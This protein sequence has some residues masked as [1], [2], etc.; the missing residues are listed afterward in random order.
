MTWEAAITGA[1]VGLVGKIVWDWLAH[2]GKTNGTAGDRTVLE[3]EMRI[4][5]V[6]ENVIDQRLQQMHDNRV[7]IIHR[8]DTVIDNQND[9]LRLLER[10]NH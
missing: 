9:I 2:R 7:E 10:R 8:L 1:V 3:W 4:K 6:V 5:A